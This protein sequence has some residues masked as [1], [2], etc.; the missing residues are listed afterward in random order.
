MIGWSKHM[1]PCSE[2]GSNRMGDEAIS[3]GWWEAF[4]IFF[5]FFFFF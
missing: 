4:F 5:F 3:R 1:T 2:L